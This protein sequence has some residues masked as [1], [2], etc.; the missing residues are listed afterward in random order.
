MRLLH[1]DLPNTAELLGAVKRMTTRE[2]GVLA[3]LAVVFAVS[4]IGIAGRI[5]TAFL[6]E[7]PA[8]GGELVEGVIGSPRFIN[9]LLATSDSDRDLASL[10]Y[11]GLVRAGADGVLVPDLAALW[12]TSDDGRTYTFTLK[13]GL[14]WHDG[15]PL[16][17]DDIAFTI[18]QAQ[19]PTLKSPK[20]AS[21][22]G[23]DVH[24]VDADT[25]QFTL[26]QP[27]SSFL[28]NATIG[29]LPKHI[30]SQVP[31][32]VFSFSEFNLEPVGS[33]PYKI[34]DIRRDKSGIPE[35][36]EL[37]PFR[38]FA[39]GKP[40]ISSLIIKFY[41]NEERLL[42]AFERREISAANALQADALKQL[43]SSGAPFRTAELALPRVFAVFF[44]QNHQPLFA[45]KE[46][47]EALTAGIDRER[48]VTEV[49][50]GYGTA[51]SGPLPPGTFGATE[52]EF[53]PL[54]GKTHAEAGRA[55]LEKA[56]WRRDEKTGVM[57]RTIDRRDTELAFS[58]VTSNT[59]ELKRAAEL[60][61]SEWEKLGARVTLNFFDIADLN[62]NIIRPRKYDALFFGEI[63]GRDPDPFSFWHSSQRNDPGLNVALYTNISV[64]KALE[65][66][67]AA[68]NAD[69][70]IAEYRKFQDE[71]ARDIPAV[72]LY[73][74]HF[75]YLL[76]NEI[77]GVSLSTV[78][79]PSERFSGIH[80]WY[81]NTDS[82]WRFFIR[83]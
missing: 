59:P 83:D 6:V 66:A 45:R 41:P 51:I 4:V 33:G 13:S 73:A 24:V 60:V 32:E 70:R 12:Q 2:R 47:R 16:T 78:T 11:S 68:T 55:I 76:P 9:P 29:I 37:K 21:W 23:V 19:N 81:I 3:S 27:Y 71:I 17:T 69:K 18:K 1:Q 44:N 8:P 36:Y 52:P 10:V 22:E 26:A 31:T 38:D 5:N 20:R 50:S 58:L 28:E 53:P 57:H 43:R 25:I 35:F 48:I 82:V 75:I 49:L 15:E 34:V 30:W 67:R 74:P 14:V 64:D 7:V 77:Q 72:F 65:A 79:T 80:E 54:K 63:V 46:V 39:L 61:K 42:R 62:Q 40:H 56:G